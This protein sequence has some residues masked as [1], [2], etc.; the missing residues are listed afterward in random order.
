MEAYKFE[1]TE[2]YFNKLDKKIGLLKK[3]NGIN[4]NRYKINDKL[5]KGYFK[6]LDFGNGIELV[7]TE[8]ELLEDIEFEYKLMKK[9]FELIYCMEGNIFCGDY[10][11]RS[12][13]SIN[14][15]ETHFWRSNDNNEG[16]MKYPKDTNISIVNVYFSE[17]FFEK[18]SYSGSQKVKKMI[19]DNNLLQITKRLNMPA[20]IVPFEQIAKSSWDR[21]LI[22]EVLYLQSKAIEIISLFVN[23]EFFK[24]KSNDNSIIIKKEDIAKLREVKSLISKNLVEPLSIDELSQ[25]VGLNTFKLKKG[26]K[27]IYKTTV[28]SYLRSLR[29]EKAREYLLKDNDNILEIANNVGYSNSSHFAAA[30][31]NKYGVNPSVYREKVRDI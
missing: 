5:G 1:D 19:C 9:G 28:F 21:G 4:I 22:S 25:R 11:L 2:D 20:I 15:G 26:F 12:D 13:V 29:M 7:M 24:K 3:V 10:N 16:W 8:F 27:E 23:N 18:L 17:T 30:F 14:P 31:R 6:Y